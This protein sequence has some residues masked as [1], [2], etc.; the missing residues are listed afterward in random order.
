MRAALLPAIATHFQ[1]GTPALTTVRCFLPASLAPARKQ[2]VA[3]ARHAIGRS[4]TLSLPVDASKGRHCATGPAIVQ[5]YLGPRGRVSTDRQAFHCS[6]PCSNRSV[7][8]QELT[9]RALTDR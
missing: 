2:S 6:M 8:W 7:I 1:Q 4:N 3:M 9:N 5:H